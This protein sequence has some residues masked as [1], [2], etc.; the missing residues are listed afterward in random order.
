MPATTSTRTQRT[1]RFQQREIPRLA[2][3][4]GWT[5]VPIPRT[6]GDAEHM[7]GRLKRAIAARA[8]VTT[9]PKFGQLQFMNELAGHDEYAPETFDEADGII[10][11]LLAPTPLQLS[12]LDDLADSL[13]IPT[14]KRPRPSTSQTAGRW[15]ERLICEQVEKLGYR[16]TSP[17]QRDLLLQLGEEQKRTKPY[18]VPRTYD[19]SD[20]KIKKIKAT[21]ADREAREQ[22]AVAA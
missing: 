17:G 1:N 16:P 20:A 11:A 15:I 13:D 21:R 2:Q 3:Q 4:L 8:G 22:E 18:A 9:P 7:I 5:G 14:S 10:K 19:E 6:W 12:T